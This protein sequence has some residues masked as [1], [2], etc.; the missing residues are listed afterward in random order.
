MYKGY[1]IF[2]IVEWAGVTKKGIRKRSVDYVFH[3]AI[4]EY[5]ISKDI[6]NA[7]KL[8]LERIKKSISFTE[9]GI[10]ERN[11]KGEK[12][13]VTGTNALTKKFEWSK[14]FYSL[15]DEV[16]INIV[17]VIEM[18]DFSKETVEICMR[19]LTISQMKEMACQE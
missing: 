15:A 16:I 5:V 19:Y 17:K 6:K 9:K 11:K 14:P 7:E 8:G 4:A 18:K 3:E 2:A 13:K 10:R 12:A 1:K